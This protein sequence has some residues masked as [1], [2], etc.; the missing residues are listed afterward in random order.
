MKRVAPLSLACLL[1]LPWWLVGC[2]AQAV[3]DKERECAA[4]PP[5]EDFLAVCTTN[6]NGSLR[7]LQVNREEE[8]HALAD[9]R[10]RYDACRAQLECADFVE[11]D[12]N[13]ECE[14]ERDDYLDALESTELGVECSTRD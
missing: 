4:D 11:A 3:C 13:G 5:G 9:A 7:A 10:V 1:A 8:C 6:Y 12:H 2:T 14:T